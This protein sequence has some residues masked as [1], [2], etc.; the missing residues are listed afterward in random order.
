[1][2]DV[3]GRRRREQ[4]NR[5][6]SITWSGELEKKNYGQSIGQTLARLGLGHFR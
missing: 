3:R 2:I 1:M 4:K 6:I 5:L